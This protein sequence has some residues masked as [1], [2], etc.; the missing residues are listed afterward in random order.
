MNVDISYFWLL[1][2]IQLILAE[3]KTERNEKEE[4]IL[5]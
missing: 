5:E 4:G 2:N 1:K 3:I